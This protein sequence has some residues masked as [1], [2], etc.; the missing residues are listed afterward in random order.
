MIGWWETLDQLSRDTQA[1]VSS[2]TK[3]NRDPIGVAIANIGYER[4]SSITSHTA[5]SVASVPGTE[6]VEETPADHLRESLPPAG[7]QAAPGA[8]SSG[9]STASVKSV[10]VAAPLHS[11]GQTSE[12]VETLHHA[13]DS[14][15]EEGGG[16]SEEEYDDDDELALARTAPST[17]ATGLGNH[18]PLEHTRA[19]TLPVYASNGNGDVAAEKAGAVADLKGS[20]PILG[21]PIASSSGAVDIGSHEGA[22]ATA[23]ATSSAS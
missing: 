15:S 17:P 23:A 12:H 9:Y 3:V 7:S 19:E 11:E 20:A 10:Q 8:Q 4:P 14:D 6:V 18:N 2:T 16:S 13:D 5:G 21:A 22:P 1:P